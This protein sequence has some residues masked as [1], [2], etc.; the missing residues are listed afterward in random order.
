[1]RA[2]IERWMATYPVGPEQKNASFRES[3][4]RSLV[5][6][7]IPTAIRALLPVPAQKHLIIGSIG[8]GAWTLTP[9]VMLLDP[10]V[11]TSVQEGY[12]IAYILSADGQ[13]LYLSLN[14]GCTVLRGQMGLRLT[15]DT[16]RA[17]ANLMWSRVSSRADRL[18]PIPM[19]LGD[20]RT[21]WR[22]KLYEQGIIAG[23]AYES[24][25]IPPEADLLKDLLEAVQ[26][27]DLIK[28]EGGWSADDALLDEA[29]QGGIRRDLRVAKRYHQHRSIERQSSHSEKVKRLQ[30]TICKGC[31]LDMVDVYGDAAAGMI[32]AHHLTPLSHLLDGEE[33]TFDPAVDFAVLC[34]NCHRAIHRLDDVSDIQA[35]RSL[36][37]QGVLKALNTA[38]R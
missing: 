19:D 12:Y 34:P 8:K 35:L 9:W 37:G 14:Q 11:T 33:V 21:V 1:M 15:G 7:D 6:R 10:S 27:Y 23:R 5:T 38:R 3:P 17:R 32:D 22:G 18:R 29:D 26:L 25:I 28:R 20:P 36:V 4:L 30:G 24:S 2:E 16:L 31:D 13:R